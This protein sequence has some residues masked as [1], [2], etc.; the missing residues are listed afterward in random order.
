MALQVAAFVKDP[1]YLNNA[2]L[3]AAIKQEVSRILQC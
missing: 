1:S 3:T 2:V